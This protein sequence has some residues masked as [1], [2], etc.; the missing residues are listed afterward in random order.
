MLGIELVPCI[1]TLG[2]LGRYLCWPENSRLQ[3]NPS[4]LLPDYEPTYE[5]IEKMLAA[6]T[7]PFRSKR[8]HIGC[9]ETHGLGRGNYLK[10]HPL[11]E[12]LYI[13]V[14]HIN[15]ISE[16]CKRLGIKPMMWGDMF[17]A[18]SSKNY[19]NYDETA[20]ITDEIKAL[21]NP[22]VDIAFW[23]Y[24]QR[25]NCEDKIIDKYKELCGMPIF[26]GGVRIWQAPLPDNI[27]TAKHVESSLAW[28]KK[29]GVREVCLT[30]WAYSKTIYQ[31]ALLELCR[32]G[33]L[34]Y[35]DTSDGLCERF[36]FITG[37]SYEA[38]VKMSYFNAIYSTEEARNN[39]SYDGSTFGNRFLDSD[40]LLNTMEVDL[41]KNPLSAYY[42]EVAEYFRSIIGKNPDWDYLYR[43]VLAVF[44]VIRTK[45][46]ISENLT[47]A[48]K[49]GDKEKLGEICDVLLPKYL[50]HLEEMNE[51]HYAHKDKYLR[52]FGI[53]ITDKWYGD[54]KQRAK[55]AIRRIRAY[56][57]GSISSIAELDDLKLAYR[58][59]PIEVKNN[60]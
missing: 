20:V 56:L 3:E 30:V 35:N 27:F 28:C 4:V 59:G 18:F 23:H 41:L 53:E 38:F 54:K 6:A 52:P 7:S 60:G 42:D 58:G 45:C 34:S 47:P 49:K 21:V 13:L 51:A 22:D 8:V 29:K 12:P 48:Y 1:Q 15:R 43:Y 57:N 14:K 17:I 16:I 2:H 10:N 9:D 31:T 24:G 26:A 5:L 19:F 25:P 36:E 11:T 37:A 44:D 55:T 32:W 40:I 50:E 39:A 46:L 33:E